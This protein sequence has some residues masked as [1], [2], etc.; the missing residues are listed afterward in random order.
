MYNYG[1]RKVALMGLF[2][3]GCVPLD[4]AQNNG[5]CNSTVNSAIDLFNA[6]LPSLVDDLNKN[7]DGAKFTFVNNTAISNDIGMNGQAYGN[8][9]YPLIICGRTPLN[10]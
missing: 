9:C 8:I 1:A 10:S 5:T 3:Y 2:Q 6:K 4:L 7:L